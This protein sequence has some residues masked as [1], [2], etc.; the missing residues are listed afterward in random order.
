MNYRDSSDLYAR[1]FTPPVEIAFTKEGN[2][3]T[4]DDWKESTTTATVRNEDDPI[5]IS[6]YYNLWIRAY[7]PPDSVLNIEL[8]GDFLRWSGESLAQ[9]LTFHYGDTDEQCLT[10]KEG[11]DTPLKLY[12]TDL[13]PGTS[14]YPVDDKSE[15]A[16]FR[17]ATPRQ[18]DR[19]RKPIPKMEAFKFTQLKYIQSAIE[20]GAFASSIDSLNDPYE[21]QGIRYPESLKVCC[22]TSAP[23][24]M[25]MWSHYAKHTGCRIDFSFDERCNGILRPVTYANEFVDHSA[26]SAK[27][28]VEH[29]YTKGVS[30]VQCSE[31]PLV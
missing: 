17:A 14:K 3:P 7:C 10:E 24:K 1:L 30:V 6:N 13:V 26:L 21:W 9:Q 31:S 15:H 23:F 4:V 19:S 29:L 11:S 16:I 22:L 20:Y 27:E 5:K 12:V 28:P 18:T 8:K 25:L 2:I